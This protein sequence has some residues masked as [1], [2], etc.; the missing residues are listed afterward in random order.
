MA[1][2]EIQNAVEGTHAEPE[3]RGKMPDGPKA[4]PSASQRISDSLVLGS[5]G[6]LSALLSAYNRKQV[7]ESV[8]AGDPQSESA[9][10]ELTGDLASLQKK[11]KS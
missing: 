10:P 7:K 3:V 8:D 5:L 2:S 4:A 6:R 9:S 1:K 11:L